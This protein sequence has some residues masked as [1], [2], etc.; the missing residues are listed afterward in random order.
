VERLVAI[1]AEKGI[2][3]QRIDVAAAF[4]SR[5]VEPA[6]A[7]LAETIRE[8]PFQPCSVPV[9]SNTTADAHSDSVETLAAT[10][11][12]H[13]VRPVEFQTQIEQMYADGARVFVEVGP[14]RV[15]SGLVSRILGEDRPH[16][17][18]AL[19]GRGPGLRG[20]LDAIGQ[21]VCAGVSLD[22]ERLFEGQR[23]MVEMSE[24]AKLRRAKVSQSP[25][26]W[27]LNGSGA[28]RIGEPP[29]RVGLSWEDVQQGTQAKETVSS[30]EPEAVPEEP[31]GNHHERE[32]IRRKVVLKKNKPEDLA[33]PDVMASYFEM[34]TQFVQSQEAVMSRYLGAESVQDRSM[35]VGLGSG[36]QRMA[37]RRSPAQD[38]RVVTRAERAA[39]QRV[40]Q[41]VLPAPEVVS[42]GP[43][44]QPAAT[45]ASNSNGTVSSAKS[46][47]NGQS[48]EPSETWLTRDAI[49]A[50]LLNL[51]EE[52]T[53]YPPEMVGLDQDLEAEL[54]IDSIK[55]VEILG[56]LLQQLPASYGERL[57]EERRDLNRK[58]TIAAM[59]DML[60]TLGG[61]ET[62]RPFDLTGAA[63]EVLVEHQLPRFEMQPQAESLHGDELGSLEPGVFVL[64]ADQRCPVYRAFSKALQDQA[65]AVERVSPG[66][67]NSDEKA[68]E[69]ISRIQSRHGTIGGLINLTALEARWLDR[70]SSKTV[71]REELQRSQKSFFL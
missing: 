50:A 37:R 56:A 13:L 5:F 14:K 67:V 22:L 10:L 23:R 63:S 19:E 57:G 20:L 34:M 29:K 59:L 55:R 49:S 51:I 68:V 44:V 45:V 4:H 47:G 30:G 7:A 46:N 31:K 65:L 42:S 43:K 36:D 39:P 33:D 70:E 26:A 11:T 62:A 9:Y 18:V 16:C 32:S 53:G 28:R 21:L 61:G 17:A 41:G 27:L 52:K 66:E 6:R 25:T 1:F 35:P 48:G 12:D 2:Q 54:G 38:R 58:S 69:A 15:L 24:A 40:A 60:E 8:I 3:A 64:L 71:W